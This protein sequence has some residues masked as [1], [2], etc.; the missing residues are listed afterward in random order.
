VP[1]IS[2]LL[3][4]LKPGSAA[5]SW[6]NSL[7]KDYPNP[8]SWKKTI[9]VHKRD[10]YRFAAQWLS[11][12]VPYA[13]RDEPIAFERAREAMARE[14]GENP[15]HISMTGSGRLGY[16]LKRGEHF[17]RPFGKGSDIDLYIVSP[18]LFAS[19]T[20]DA[21]LFAARVKSGEA[22]PRDE[23]EARDWKWTAETMSTYVEE[24]HFID[25]QHL[26]R[27]E[28][29]PIVRRIYRGLERFEGSLRYNT[30][31]VNARASVRVY[32]DWDAAIAQLGGTLLGT[33]RDEGFEVVG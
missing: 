31:L 27:A 25:H 24:R 7:P 19:L 8:R 21:M 26:P 17:G 14:I 33:L 15:K 6:G 11:E 16:S 18:V 32:R 12:G 1:A 23:R 30:N 3:S 20:H 9:P 13:F 10:V 28:R 4:K 29:Y 2:R 5:E 22:K